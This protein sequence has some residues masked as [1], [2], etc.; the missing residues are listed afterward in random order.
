MVVRRKRTPDGWRTENTIEERSDVESE[1]QVVEQ[2]AVTGQSS[3]R[4]LVASGETGDQDTRRS[5]SGSE[6]EEKITSSATPNED[7]GPGI[8]TP[9]SSQPGNRA[10]P[11]AQPRA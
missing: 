8:W 5:E 10:T 9:G 4:S 7:G 6:V 2:Q 3:Y 11:P 1:P